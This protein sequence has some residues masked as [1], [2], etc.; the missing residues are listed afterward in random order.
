MRVL[1]KVTATTHEPKLSEDPIM[2]TVTIINKAR[3]Y[4]TQFRDSDDHIHSLLSFIQRSEILMH[5]WESCRNTKYY[6]NA[7]NVFLKTTIY[8]DTLIEDDS[9]NISRLIDQAELGGVYHC[10]Q[11]RN[12]VRACQSFDG[13]IETSVQ[14][15]RE[16]LQWL[17]ETAR[18]DRIWASVSFK[19]KKMF[20]N[21]A[22][23]H[24]TTETLKG[25]KTTEE[26]E[27][28]NEDYRK[29]LALDEALNELD[30]DWEFVKTA[31]KNKG[32]RGG[33]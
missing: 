11:H 7:R 4:H 18:S 8:A 27:D 25:L 22:K 29:A 6:N 33:Y 26:I 17:E 2:P 31:L 24:G 5:V 3:E 1:E 10:R 28:A 13:E 20:E 15:F 21:A 14:E 9:K 23:V 32:Y 30:E 19:R 12:K 16:T